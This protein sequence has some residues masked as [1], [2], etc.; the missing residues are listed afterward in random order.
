MLD[1]LVYELIMKELVDVRHKS[2]TFFDSKTSSVYMNV[3]EFELVEDSFS[4]ISKLRLIF[5]FLVTVA[6]DPACDHSH[7]I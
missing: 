2:D 5:F 7:D 6:W 1:E 4:G 3:L